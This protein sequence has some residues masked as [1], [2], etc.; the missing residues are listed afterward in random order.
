M[1][2]SSWSIPEYTDDCTALSPAC[3]SRA[4][5]EKSIEE[6]NHITNLITFTEHA[7]YL[8]KTQYIQLLTKFIESFD[9]K[10]LTNIIFNALLNM[11]SSLRYKYLTFLNE[12]TI[13][14]LSKQLQHTTSH[15]S[16]S[17]L[18]KDTIISISQFLSLKELSNLEI[19]NRFLFKPSGNH[20]IPSYP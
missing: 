9:A 8:H 5:T 2:L 3:F 16:L 19:C 20:L 13:D 17:Y 1:S 10:S 14:L 6:I 12:N 4:A 7:S 18:N 11:Q 15:S